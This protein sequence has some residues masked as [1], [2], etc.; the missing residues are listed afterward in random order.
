M[1]LQIRINLDTNKRPAFQD[2]FKTPWSEQRRRHEGYKIVLL[3]R[4][5]AG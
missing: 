1:H 5:S 4:V 3:R 2:C